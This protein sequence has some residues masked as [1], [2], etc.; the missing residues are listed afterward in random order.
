MQTLP[1]A[2][3]AGRGAPSQLRLALLAFPTV[4]R[5]GSSTYP[6]FFDD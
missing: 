6:N 3:T 1:R 5:M 2:G 4:P